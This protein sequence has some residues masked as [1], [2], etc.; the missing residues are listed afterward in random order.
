M[1][2]CASPGLG[3]STISRSQYQILPS[4]S[5][6]THSRVRS[7]GILHERTDKQ[8]K[9]RATHTPW[10]R[11]ENTLLNKR[12]ARVLENWPRRVRAWFTMQWLRPVISRLIRLYELQS[13]T[14]KLLVKRFDLC[15]NCTISFRGASS[16]SSEECEVFS[17]VYLTLITEWSS[18]NPKVLCPKENPLENWG[19]RCRPLL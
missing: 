13:W 2:F 7:G 10:F 5:P 8:H 19:C 14:S 9:G 4:S 18:V 16:W 12:S 3:M 15:S 11:S 1:S 17:V 6:N